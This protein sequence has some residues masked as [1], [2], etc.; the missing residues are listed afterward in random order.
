MRFHAPRQQGHPVVGV[1]LGDDAPAVEFG[2]VPRPAAVGVR[3]WDAAVGEGASI[4]S[5]TPLPRGWGADA[6]A[7]G[8]VEPQGG[9]GIEQSYV[10]G[11][12]SRLGS[13]GAEVGERGGGVVLLAFE[14]VVGLPECRG[15]RVVGVGVL[16]LPQDRGLP[17]AD[18]GEQSSQPVA[19]GLALPGGIV[20]DLCKVG[21]EER[22]PPR[23]EDPFG[24]EAGHP[25]QGVFVEVDD[26]SGGQRT[27]LGCRGCS[28]AA[29]TR[30]KSGCGSGCRTCAARSR[31]T[32]CRGT[33]S[34]RRWSCSM[35]RAPGPSRAA[36]AAGTSPSR[37][38]VARR[39]RRSGA[40]RGTAMLRSG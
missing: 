28:R 4:G 29:S 23:P 7:R 32:P 16:G 17:A 14:I 11:W 33:G 26:F 5:G 40:G 36:P 35:L 20:V 30:S 1:L 37:C 38:S 9:Q 19:F 3:G 22:L 21:G 18:V 31:R 39:W 10:G 15:E 13:R 24:V 34:R 6:L 8:E 2:F 27:R 12:L 25:K